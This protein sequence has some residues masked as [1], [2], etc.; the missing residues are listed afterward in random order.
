MNGD[1]F[2]VLVYV[3]E[4]IFDFGHC[5]FWK[6][7]IYIY[8]KMIDVNH[9]LTTSIFYNKNQYYFFHRILIITSRI[10]YF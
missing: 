7:K 9:E 3:L 5:V 1:T 4:I 8:W 6:R 2:T 10:I